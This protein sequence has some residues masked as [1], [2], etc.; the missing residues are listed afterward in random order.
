M[1]KKFTT[2]TG[3]NIIDTKENVIPIYVLNGDKIFY[4]TSY[5]L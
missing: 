5:N 1:R 4:N 3:L 2:P